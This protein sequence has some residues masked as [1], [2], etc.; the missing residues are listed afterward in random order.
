MLLRLRPT[1]VLHGR[2]KGADMK[3]ENVFPDDHRLADPPALQNAGGAAF[4]CTPYPLRECPDPRNPVVAAG[5]DM[6]GAKATSPYWL[7]KVNGSRDGQIMVGANVAESFRL[8]I[9]DMIEVSYT[10]EEQNV[11]KGKRS[12]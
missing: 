12:G 2:Y 7:W 4:H 5:T 1:E 10:P 3:K 9:G 8:K 11:R 6:K